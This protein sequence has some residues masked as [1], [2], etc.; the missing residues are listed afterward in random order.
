MPRHKGYIRYQQPREIYRSIWQARGLPKDEYESMETYELRNHRW[1]CRE[2]INGYLIGVVY[3]NGNISYQGKRESIVPPPR[4]TKVIEETLL[5][6][7]LAVKKQLKSGKYVIY[8]E[9]YGNKIH[10]GEDFF[11]ENLYFAVLDVLNVK[12]GLYMDSMQL[13]SFCS[14]L[15][16]KTANIVFHGTLDEV[17]EYVKSRPKSSYGDFEIE[18]VIAK[19]MGN[20]LR[21]DG[22]RIMLKVECDVLDPPKDKKVYYYEKRSAWKPQKGGFEFNEK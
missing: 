11:G 21:A 18:G 15:G 17:E 19:P 14:S 7:P 3:D 13:N 9:M 5:K 10:H 22:S 16:V 2:K 12:T 8:L 20:F 4:F 1:T 6:Y